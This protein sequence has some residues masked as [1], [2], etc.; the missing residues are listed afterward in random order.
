M[1]AVWQ[2][3]RWH[4]AIA[5]VV[6]GMRVRFL[7]TPIT[8]DEGGYLSVARYWSRGATL[9]REA[10]VDRPQGLLVLFR[11]LN[12]VGLDSPFGVR[13]LAI[14]AGLVG[15]FS[16]ASIASTLVGRR[17]YVPAG[18]I[19]GVLLGVPQ[20]EGFIANADLPSGVDPDPSGR[21]YFVVKNSWGT[22]YAD[23]GFVYVSGEFLEQW[24]FEYVTIAS[25]LD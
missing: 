12:V 21:G 9:Y 7:W 11:G 23:C 1:V 17:A 5:A 18:L 20:Y 14:A 16:C 2:R 19:T 13:L 4:L 15:A 6:V 22:S 10:W 24:G 25:D 8:S 3:W